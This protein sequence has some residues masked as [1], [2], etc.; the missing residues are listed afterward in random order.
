MGSFREQE[1]CRLGFLLPPS[2]SD[3][4]PEGHL[5]WF[6]IAAVEQLNTC[7]N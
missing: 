4:L 3:W 1:D 6:I 7:W 2:L 5:A